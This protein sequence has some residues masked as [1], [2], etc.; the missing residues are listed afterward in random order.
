[1][2]IDIAMPCAKYVQTPCRTSK[3]STWQIPHSGKHAR[4]LQKNAGWMCTQEVIWQKQI[5][6]PP[7][8]TPECC[9]SS[10]FTSMFASISIQRFFE[11]L[12][13]LISILGMQDM[14]HTKSF[15]TSGT[16]TICARYV[17]LLRFKPSHC[18]GQCT[19][20]IPSWNKMP[21]TW[22]P[23]SLNLNVCDPFGGML[24]I[25]CKHW[26]AA[27]SFK[28]SANKTWSSALTLGLN[29][30]NMGCGLFWRVLKIL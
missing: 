26:V 12:Q 7:T 13:C 29:L 23:S 4:I 30:R 19:V 28:R 24:G 22:T 2:I 10:M 1:M 9:H 8:P 15:Q 17:R 11:K 3:N 25:V 20:G 6:W 21:L 14:Q 5:Y 18:H 16:F 27:R